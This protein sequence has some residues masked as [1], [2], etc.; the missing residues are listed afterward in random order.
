MNVT[1]PIVALVFLVF[2]RVMNAMITAANRVL[3]MANR[4]IITLSLSFQMALYAHVNVVANTNVELNLCK[5]NVL[6][7]NAASE[8]A[9]NVKLMGKLL[10]EIPDS[11]SGST[12][13]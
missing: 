7:Q 12:A 2:A 3:L 11:K 4:T 6:G 13:F 8:D 10:L 5:W 1:A 9:N